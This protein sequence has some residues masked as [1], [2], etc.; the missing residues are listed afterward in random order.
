MPESLTPKCAPLD[1]SAAHA[2]NTAPT[3][4]ERGEAWNRKN[5]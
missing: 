3:R 1:N 5:A 2:T 4:L